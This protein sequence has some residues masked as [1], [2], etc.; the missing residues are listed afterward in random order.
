[1]TRDVLALMKAA[2]L[3]HIPVIVG[4]IIPPEDAERLRAEGVAA[5]YTPKDFAINKIMGDIVDAGRAQY[6]GRGR[7]GRVVRKAHRRQAKS[8]LARPMRAA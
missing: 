2:G 6:S 4:G 5:V 1:M 7:E 3:D 8:E